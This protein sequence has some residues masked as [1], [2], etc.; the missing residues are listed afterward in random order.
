MATNFKTGICI[1]TLNSR[2]LCSRRR[3]CQISRILLENDIDLLAVQET[4]MESEEQTEQM[5]Q[6]FR[7]RYNVCVCHAVGR[8]GGCVVF[9]RSSI[10]VVENVSTCDSGRLVVCDFSVSG[11]PWRVVC[12]YAPNRSHEREL[13]FRAIEGFLKTE[14]NVV[15]LGDFNCVC[16]AED[17]TT[18]FN[19]RDRSA[20]LLNKIVNETGLEDV[21]YVMTREGEVGY[22]HFQGHSHA[23][24][25]RIYLSAKL[26]PLCSSYQIQHLSFSDH[27]LVK[28]NIG[29]KRKAAKFNWFLWK[30]NEKLLQDEIFVTKTK[31][32]L[33]NALRLETNNFIAVWEQMK[34]DIKMIAIERACV[35]RNRERQQERQLQSE[36]DYMLSVENEVPGKFKKEIKEAKAKLEFIDD[37]KYRGA[38][39]RARTERL[40]MGETPTKRVL[41]EEKKHAANKEINEIRY[42]NYITRDR[43][44]IKHAFVEFYTQLLSHTINDPERFKEDFLTLMPR[45]EDSERELL[46]VEITVAEIESAIDNLG[47]GKSPGPDGLGAAIYK[48]FKTEMAL[49]LHRVIR[50][51]YDKQQTPH[52]FRTAHVVLIPKTDDPAK[53]LSVESYRPISLSNTDYKIYTK[54]LARRLQS[55]VTSLVGPHQTCG[56][57][58]RTIF[59]NIHVTRSILECCDANNDRVAMIQ[60]DLHKAFDKVVH[61]ILFLLLEHVNVGTVITEGVRMVYHD[62]RANLVINKEVSA[63]IPVRSSV[64]QGC[65]LSPLLFALYL[66][67]FCLRI[68]ASPSI[69]GYTFLTSGIRILAYADDVAVFCSDK[70]SVQEVVRI[71]REFCAATGSAISWPKCLGVWHGQWQSTPEVYC[72]MNWKIMPGKYLGVP[73][74]HYRNA[75]EYWSEERQRIKNCTDKWGGRNLSMFAKASVCNVF[76]IAKVFYVLQV[77]TMTRTSVQKMHRVFATFIWGSQWER[78]S[79]CNLFHRVK[80]GGLGLLHLFFKQLVSRFMFAR[81]QTDNFLRTVIQARLQTPLPDFVVSSFSFEAGPLSPYLREVVT[82]TRLLKERFSYEYLSDVTKKKLYRD[83][84][85]V[86]LPVPVYRASCRLGSER[87]V[88]KRVKRMPVRPSVKTFFFQVHTGTLPVLPW[89]KSKGL[90]VPWSVNCLICGKPETINHIF[91]DCHDAVF[92]WDVLQRTIK[93][94]LPINAFGIRFL[95]CAA[96]GEVP[97]DMLM[98]LCMHSVWR[99]RMD[100]RHMRVDARSARDYFVESMLY[101]RDV[102]KALPEPPEWL[103]VLD[104]LAS[105]KPF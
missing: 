46:E 3:Q 19:V 62:C 90:F 1:A 50:E 27:C 70:E 45:L 61:E 86:F 89:L 29:E 71:A 16:R 9:I 47:N 99:T 35:L 98:L 101:T 12:V 28:V 41:S 103:P 10:A 57:K 88:F 87:D 75:T 8:S 18:S 81:D 40:W 82:A 74:D 66:E 32:C 30:F 31:E 2:G 64:K 21:G 11:M 54:V 93:K 20:E 15:V 53:L 85:D 84:L 37:E 96:A 73:L 58:G 65:A 23:R 72:N 7:S 60:L 76:L 69:R 43:E 51:C 83:L 22:T 39:I 14:R 79:R 4:K 92:L 77:L 104:Q 34:C 38:M 17:K 48:F 26:V 94:E 55:V 36:L 44:Q 105:V 100:V 6:V 13:F 97:S 78:T 25:D 63:S 68:L 59:T 52:S 80:Y 102:F 5:V 49:A 42:R 33:S 67:P 95:P 24:L 56:I 91:L